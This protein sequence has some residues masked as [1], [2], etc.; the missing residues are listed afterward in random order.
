MMDK[1]SSKGRWYSDLLAC[2]ECGGGVV[3]LE[4]AMKCLLCDL[5]RAVQHPLDLRAV[6]P[7]PATFT[8]SRVEKSAP[9]SYLEQVVIERPDITYDGP[10]AIRDSR[11]FMSVIKGFVA[12]GAAVLDLG[13]GSR[14]QA[15]PLESIG[16]RYVGVDIS[17]SFADVLADA[18]ALPFKADTIDC[19]LGYAVLEHFHSPYIAIR[20]IERVL[21][22][23]GIFVGAVSQGEPFHDSYFHHTAWGLISLIGITDKLKVL[24]LWESMDTLTALARM[25]R[26]PKIVRGL[27]KMVDRVH[28]SLPF[29]APRKNA[30]PERDKSL[31]RLFRGG[32]VCF[33]IQK[34][35]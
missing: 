27:I 28:T 18:H 21:A 12:P 23:N 6:D 9:S 26:Y 33:V 2:P 7:L 5:S 20:E 19:I 15:E 1:G 10:R 34:R 22:P 32:G 13:C 11:E 30:W 4:D 3:I 24:R 35:S 31:D 29:L 17:G 25:G 8:I 14:D 16:C